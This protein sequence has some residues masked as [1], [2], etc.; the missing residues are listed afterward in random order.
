MALLGPG[1]AVP[2]AAAE[3]LLGADGVIALVARAADSAGGTETD[4]GSGKQEAKRLLGDLEN[5][6]AVRD[7]LP[8][9]E[10]VE[11]W[12]QFYGRLRMLPPETL[13]NQYGPPGPDDLSMSSL[14]S[15]LPPPTAWEAL[16]ARVVSR[17]K[18]DG[19][20][21]EKMM[22]GLEK[23]LEELKTGAAL[24][25]NT[26]SSGFFRQLGFQGRRQDAGRGSAAI[27][28]TFSAYL[29]SLNSERPQ[30]HMTVQVPDLVA[31]AGEERAKQLMLQ[32]IAIPGLSLNIP[33][34][35]S[36]LELA[37]RLVLVRTSLPD[38]R[39]CPA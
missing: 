29:Q 18:T 20:A 14:L 34:G 37:K 9:E 4:S 1:A 31:L 12:L 13:K 3:G 16:K 8:A 11:R 32:A 15:A 38:E 27:P 22:A 39:Q 23:A 26:A 19:G 28:E 33:S 36:T 35:G 17:Q 6:K 10:A 5:F 24:G 25:G 2:T 21:Q 30:G 7:K